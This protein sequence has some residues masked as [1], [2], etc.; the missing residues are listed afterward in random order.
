VGRLRREAMVRQTGATAKELPAG[1]GLCRRSGAVKK[2]LLSGNDAQE[3][4]LRRR[5]VPESG[6]R[7]QEEEK[8]AREKPGKRSGRA[9]QPRACPVEKSRSNQAVVFTDLLCR[10]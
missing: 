5:S 9:G 3:E 10:L 8:A 4:S 2:A 1:N 6:K 7:E